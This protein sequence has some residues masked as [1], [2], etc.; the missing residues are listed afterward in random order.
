MVNPNEVIDQF[1]HTMRRLRT[2]YDSF[3]AR[4]GLTLS[5]V[6]VLTT[7][8]KMEGATQVELSQALQI[9]A[10]TLKRQIDALVSAGFIERRALEGDVRKRAL[11]LTE[12]AHRS[13]I[14]AL[15]CKGRLQLFEGVTPEDL[16]TFSR[17]LGQ[18]SENITR[19]EDQ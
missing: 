9:E 8:S 7:L 12:I 13:E 15:I 18:I 4:H 10:P 2:V 1:T 19:I 6:R 17:V 16:E 14:N 11:H 5:R 3:A